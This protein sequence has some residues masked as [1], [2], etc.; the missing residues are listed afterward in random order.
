MLNVGHSDADNAQYLKQWLLLDQNFSD[1]LWLLASNLTAD[2]T[3][4]VNSG[5][6]KIGRVPKYPREVL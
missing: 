1:G 2:W 6:P 3:I 5:D 4:V